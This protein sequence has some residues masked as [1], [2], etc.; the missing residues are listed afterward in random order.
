M[1]KVVTIAAFV[2]FAV[3]TALATWILFVVLSEAA[4]D[5]DV[6]L[7]PSLLIYAVLLAVTVALG[8]AAKRAVTPLTAAQ[9]NARLMKRQRRNFFDRVLGRY[10]HQQFQT[11]AIQD[12]LDRGSRAV[13]RIGRGADNGFGALTVEAEAATARGDPAAYLYWRGVG[14]IVAG[15]DNDRSIAALL[16]A[17]ELKSTDFMTI[18]FLQNRYMAKGDWAEAQR[19]AE[20][21]EALAKVDVQRVL[22]VQNAASMFMLMRDNRKAAML[23]EKAVDLARSVEPKLLELLAGVAEHL[24]VHA[25]TL[26]EK[27]DFV[28][29]R[30]LLTGYVNLRRILLERLGGA[31]AKAELAKALIAAGEFLVKRA[32]TD[33]GHA[34]LAEG[35]K[36]GGTRSPAAAA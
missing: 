34:F 17:N 6:V 9:I 28:E 35:E 4:L 23:A 26:G 27:G 29:A 16:R 13:Q 12:A 36:L 32:N 14:V 7:W 33:E 3:L 18:F 24:E 30:W 22:L 15:L 25:T 2:L 31:E 11:T 20:I 10:L 5:D 8:V 21:G 1:L 19:V